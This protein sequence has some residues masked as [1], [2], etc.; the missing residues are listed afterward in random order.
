MIG[1]KTVLCIISIFEPIKS[2]K[3]LWWSICKIDWSQD[4]LKSCKNF[5][6]H[7]RKKKS[8]T[9][10]SL[11]EAFI[12]HQLTH[13]MM[14]DCSLNYKFNTWKFLAQNWEHGENML[15]TDFFLTFRTISVHNVFSPCSGK[16]RASDKDL[17]VIK[18][19]SKLFFP[20]LP[21][22]T[23]FPKTVCWQMRSGKNTI[24][25]PI[26]QC[27]KKLSMMWFTLYHLH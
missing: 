6:L 5:N 18:N 27:T 2:L 25:N 14:T 4:N 3:S 9:G 26:L 13:N 1:P 15:C 23:P 24:W 22:M 20:R 19:Y 7:F 11:S 21:K 16:R 8:S 10:K 12:L 17:P